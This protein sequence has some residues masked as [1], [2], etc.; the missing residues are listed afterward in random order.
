MVKR[1]EEND[2]D[3]VFALLD[4]LDLEE[5]EEQ[6]PDPPVLVTTRVWTLPCGHANFSAEKSHISA[7]ADGFCCEEGRGEFP[8]ITSGRLSH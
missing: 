1:V 7:R 3:D 4:L 6:C 2:E 8:R 5:E